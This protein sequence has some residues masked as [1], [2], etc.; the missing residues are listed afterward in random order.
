[1]RI[2]VT[3]DDGIESEGIKTLADALSEKGHKSLHRYS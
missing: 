3:N 2:L 1:M